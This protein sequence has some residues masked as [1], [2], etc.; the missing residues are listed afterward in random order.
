M[1]FLV[2]NP[3][4]KNAIAKRWRR[5]AFSGMA[6][7]QLASSII[8]SSARSRAVHR[9]PARSI[10][11]KSRCCADA[12]LLRTVYQKVQS[13]LSMMYSV[14]FAILEC[15]AFLS[16]KFF[17]KFFVY[18]GGGNYSIHFIQIMLLVVLGVF[19]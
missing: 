15:I 14:S 17:H 8:Q 3:K 11:T 2:R 1:K 18:G 4:F 5:F 9:L 12:I 10:A 19:V 7:P 13:V 6:T 16:G